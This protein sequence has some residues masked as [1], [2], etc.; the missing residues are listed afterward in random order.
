[1]KRTESGN[2]PEREN[3]GV[4]PVPSEAAIGPDFPPEPIVSDQALGVPIGSD[5]SPFRELWTIAWPTILTMTSYTVMQFIDAYM[6]SFVGP[7]E[8]AAQGNGGIYS[9]APLAFAMGMLTI[10]NTFVSQNLG[11]GHP[12]R[13]PR[14][15]WNALWIAVVFWVL[16]IP[17]GLALPSI[18]QFMH[19]SSD[20]TLARLESQYGQILVFGSIFAMAS[21]SISNFFFGLHRP[22]VVFIATV[23][24]NLANVG[25]NYVLIFGYFGFP[26]LGLA[27]AAYGTLF[28]TVVELIIPFAVF[29]GPK[30]NRELGSRSA[31]RID[32]SAMR[33]LVRVGWPRSLTF[34]NELICWAIFMVLIVGYF[35]EEHMTA[36]WITLRYM[37]LS[38]MPATGIGVAVTAMVG[39]YIGAG[40]PDIANQR[41]YLGVKMAMIYMGICALCFVVF[42]RSLVGIFLHDE[43]VESAAIIINIG[44][45]MLICAAVFQMF[46]AMAITFSSALA[47]AGDT[48]W[49]G[50]VNVIA[51]WVFIIG[52]GM[53][54][55]KFLPQ[56][57]S[58]GP[59]IGAAMFIISV[60]IIFYFRWRAGGW[61]KINLVNEPDP[62]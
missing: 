59:W 49:P 36:G 52:V 45:K 12:Q 60:G 17:F 23:L 18:F 10:V 7:T 62:F 26:K 44:M 61:R 21:R 58:I 41:A 32:M 43:N 50:V 57:Q 39:K 5:L 19:G 13:A 51:S 31:W 33:D 37:H 11:A 48:V 22:K 24:G 3:T 27:G 47:G 54:F 42:R 46:D 55:V 16:L 56:W 6:V 4:A 8:V 20:P 30:M 14:Y 29:L 53:L 35:G 25:A 1:M 28:G 9:F 38:F 15:A 34:G 40:K 2:Q